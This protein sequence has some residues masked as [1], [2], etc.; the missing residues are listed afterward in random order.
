MKQITFFLILFFTSL[1]FTSPTWAVWKIISAGTATGL[2]NPSCAPVSAGQV[3]CAVRSSASVLMVNKFNGTIWGTWTSL[4][5]SVRTNPSCTNDGFGKVFCGAVATDGSLQV[6]IFSGGVWGSPTKISGALYS[7]PSCA[8]YTAGQILCAARSVTGGLFYTIYNGSWSSFK[9]IA[10]AAV[11]SPSC[12]TDNNH[13]VICAIYTIGGSTLV[14]RFAA[15]VWS[16]FL[17]VGGIAGGEPDC[18]SLNL[19]GKAVCFAKAY[20]S[21]I[22]GSV[23]NGLAWTK[24][25]WTGYAPISGTVND[26]ANCTSQSAGRLVCGA[27]AVTDAAFYANIYNGSVWSGWSKIGSVRVGSPS[28]AALGTGQVACLVNGINNTFTSFVGP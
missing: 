14:N 20:N 4:P 10:T 23:Y 12:T 26:N 17:N 2:G 24:G 8:A 1:L 21:G 27:I 6:T 3:V 19:F 13:G 25:N 28:C 9:N 22:F 5:G 18:T 15:G 16:G 7:Q 11:S